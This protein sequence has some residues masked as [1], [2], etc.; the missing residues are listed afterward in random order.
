MIV[1]E[2]TQGVRQVNLHTLA[3]IGTDRQRF[4][5]RLACENRFDLLIKHKDN[6]VW[7]VITILVMPNF[8]LNCGDIVRARE[9][10]IGTGIAW[11]RCF[12]GLLTNILVLPFVLVW[13]ETPGVV[14]VVQ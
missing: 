9:R 12:R 11:A 3:S 10:I 13:W 14:L 8:R 2:F 4:G 7:V 5:V 1:I 6:T